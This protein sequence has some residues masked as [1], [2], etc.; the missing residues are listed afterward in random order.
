MLKFTV[1]MW[2]VCIQSKMQIS[3]IGW[4]QAAFNKKRK[5]PTAFH[6]IDQLIYVYLIIEWNIWNWNQ[7]LIK[8][9]Q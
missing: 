8:H 4:D 1:G 7:L 6:A 2:Q 5:K 3:S 9:H